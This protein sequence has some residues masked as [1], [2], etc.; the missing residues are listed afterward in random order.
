[1]HYLCASVG[2]AVWPS[3]CAWICVCGYVRAY[4]CACVSHARQLSLPLPRYRQLDWDGILTPTVDEFVELTMVRNCTCLSAAWLVD[5]SGWVC[6]WQLWLH[7][8]RW[9][10]AGGIRTSRGSEREPEPEQCDP[11]VGTCGHQR[12]LQDASRGSAR[13]ERRSRVR[14]SCGHS[15]SS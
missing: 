11:V 2:V 3:V 8:R 6:C 15:K 10:A 7:W 14:S 5:R 4:V 12:C 9:C 1:M 13:A